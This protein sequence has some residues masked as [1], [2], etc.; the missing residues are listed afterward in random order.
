MDFLSKNLITMVTFIEEKNVLGR[1]YHVYAFYFLIKPE[2][3]DEFK[4]RNFDIS[5]L[6][7]LNNNL[8]D[9]NIKLFLPLLCNLNQEDPV[10]TE[11]Q[12]SNY[13]NDLNNIYVYNLFMDIIKQKKYQQ[14]IGIFIT[15]SNNI[16]KEL[17]NKSKGIFINLNNMI[18][19][20]YESLMGLYKI[21]T[22]DTKPNQFFIV[23]TFYLNYYHEY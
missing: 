6:I 12:L 19:E 20:N 21:Y 3:I 11:K 23:Q 18:S 4:K 5:K 16:S 13:K 10:I 14:K 7:I 17:Q 1:I 9:K 2:N 22:K 8:E 15:V